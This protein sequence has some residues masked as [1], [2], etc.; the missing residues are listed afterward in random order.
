MWVRFPGREDPMQEGMATDSNILAWEIL[1][2][3]DSPWGHKRVRHN[4]ATK[5]DQQLVL[6]PL[7]G[8][9]IINGC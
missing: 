3:E 6:C 9:F 4:L 1:W 7:S 2:T 5:Q 8:A